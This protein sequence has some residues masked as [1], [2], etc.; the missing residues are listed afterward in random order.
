[1]IERGVIW[2]IIKCVEQLVKAINRFIKIKQLA[3][4]SKI[5]LRKKKLLTFYYNYI[6]VVKMKKI[7]FWVAADDA[8]KQNKK[9]DNSRWFDQF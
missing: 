6:V 2:V 1:M 8:L 3:R 5:Y 7:T 4:I 9:M